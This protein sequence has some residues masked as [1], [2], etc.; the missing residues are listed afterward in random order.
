MNEKGMY[1][2]YR[3]LVLLTGCV[4]IL[5][6]YTDMI[7]YAPIL[8]GVA[9]DLKIGMGSA[10]N[11]MMA[12]VLV[13]AVV[14]IWGGVVC[15]KY[16]ITV[17]LVLGL[18]CASVPAV[19]MPWI[20]HNYGVVL[21]CRLIQG[22]SV[23]FIFA[24]IGP[25]TALWFPPQEQGL[26]GGVLLGGISIGSALGVVISPALFGAIASWQKTVAILSI[27][28]WI[29]ILLALLI[30]RRPPSPEVAKGLMEAM[31]S[32]A[33]EVTF[34]KA[35]TLPMTWICSF[36]VFFNAWGLYCLYNL[37]PPYLAAKAPMGV[38][39][40]PATAGAISLALTI[41]GIFAPLVG[42]IFFD[43]V[44]KGN[45]KP[46]IVIGFI[47]A[48]IFTYLVLTS[49][50][51]SS[52]GLL[53]VCLMI[54]GWGIPFMNP[55]LSAFIV[56][57]YPPSMVGRM[58]GFCFGFGTFGGALGLYLGGMTIGRL[59]SFFWAIAMISIACILGFILS[60]FLKSRNA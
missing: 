22:A 4:A 19:L 23:G 32:K 27:P 20:G 3:W 26:A 45:P 5:S 52:M 15:D 49:P 44:G 42:G 46:N 30:T 16:G 55:S 6:A 38:G 13:V 24:T 8:G 35:L 40:G 48:G 17:A 28:G 21:F 54:A 2:S 36:I 1:S 59:G 14:L 60:F 10:T 47:L 33:G 29:G 18:L 51:Y 34:S 7:V 12:F 25:I 57:N 11:L 50:V 58:V 39:L 43:K 37:V 56:M 41:V 31:K 53:V 9:E